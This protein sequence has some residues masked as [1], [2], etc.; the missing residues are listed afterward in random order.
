MAP[1]S[2]RKWTERGG[3]A[4]WIIASQH[5]GADFSIR[6]AV[7]SGSWPCAYRF[8]IRKRG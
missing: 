7:C 3:P 6:L 2:P 8:P 5:N 4:H 1:M